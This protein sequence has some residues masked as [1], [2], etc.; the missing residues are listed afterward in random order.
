MFWLVFGYCCKKRFVGYFLCWRCSVWQ[1]LKRKS[2]KLAF[3]LKRGGKGLEIDLVVLL[4]QIVVNAV[5]LSP[6]LWLAGRAL[7]GAQKAKFFDAVW[8]VVLGTVISSIFNYFFSVVIVS[9]IPTFNYFLSGIVASIILLIILLGLVKH[10]F[11]CGWWK[12]LA[13]AILAVI[14]FIMIIAILSVVV[15]GIAIGLSLF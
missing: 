14:F 9:V 15:L 8:I 1:K 4:I 11:D 5:I 3:W 12:A 10:F 6:V 7:V 2:S 13:I